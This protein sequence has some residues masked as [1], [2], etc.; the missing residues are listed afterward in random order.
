MGKAACASVAG[1]LAAAYLAVKQ[2][3]Y[4]HAIQGVE[5]LK[6]G[7]LCG[8]DIREAALHTLRWPFCQMPRS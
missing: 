6:A 2:C 7:L 3:R 1:G 5:S 8:I 4:W